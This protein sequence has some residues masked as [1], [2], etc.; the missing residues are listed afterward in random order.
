MVRTR[1]GRLLGLFSA[2]LCLLA[3]PLASGQTETQRNGQ[4]TT[5]QKPL[6]A[7][8]ALKNIQVLRGISVNE[9][10]ETM[11]FF[12][13]SL[14]LNCTGCHVA[15][16]SGSWDRYADD[17]PIKQK[18]RQMILMVNAINRNYF[19]GKREVTCYTCH[20]AN[21]E[22]EITPSLAEQYG[23]PPPQ[24]PNEIFQ[25][26]PGAP[27]PE[28]VLDKYIQAVGGAQQLAVFTSFTA[29]GTYKGYDDIE[30]YPVEIYA[31]APGQRATIIHDVGGD[32]T[33]ICDGREAWV[34]APETY[35]P[36]P[37]LALSA[38]DLDAAKIEAELAFPGRIK[39]VLANWRVGFP[40]TIDN[41]EL[42]VMQAVSAA[43]NNVKLY[44][45]RQSGLLV[46]LVRYTNLPVGFVPTQTD[47]ADYRD[48]SGIKMPFKITTTWVDGR[49]VTELTSIQMNAPC[50][51]GEICETGATRTIQKIDGSVRFENRS[52]HH[53]FADTRYKH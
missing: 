25:Q 23:S 51:G 3:V 32:R 19:G 7:E 37:V 5:L 2:A 8:D 50:Y 16:S 24:D 52:L 29:T 43:G 41:R 49:S 45:D 39:E 26:V 21:N 40:V 31:K 33:E 38:G 11:G 53:N 12:A 30:K 47:Y 22:P 28:Q 35:T 6:L 18:A 17:I 15:E 10:M 48:V 46:R 34:S 42:T 1:S 27:A 4:S 9:F 20:H 36:V 44:F 14:N 13:A